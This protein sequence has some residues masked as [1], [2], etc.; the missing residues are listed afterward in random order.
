[1]DKAE[2]ISKAPQ[3]YALAIISHLLQELTATTKTDI[4]NSFA[5]PHE[6][7]PDEIY[8]RVSEGRMLDLAIRLLVDRRLVTLEL[9]DFAPPL[10]VPAEEF[11]TEWELLYSDAGSL[12]W[13]YERVGRTKNVWLREALDN[14]VRE[15]RR[16]NIT[17]SDFDKPEREW[18]PIP[19]DRGSPE[20]A[21]VVETLEETVK[22]ARNDNGYSIHAPGEQAVVIDG[23]TSLAARLKEAD[24]IPA[25][26]IRTGIE[27]LGR[28]I[29]RFGKAGLGIAATLAWEAT[30]DWIKKRG[31]V[32]FDLLWSLF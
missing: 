24:T 30:K 25:I 1:M 16:L 15:E 10:I 23:L 32:L 3:Y 17:D 27:H 8:Y 20:L 31:G 14:I 13:K 5:Q 12:Y 6:D 2:F 9:D 26:Y 11:R 7:D 28:L 18:E 21:K 19:L 4:V 29:R 22:L